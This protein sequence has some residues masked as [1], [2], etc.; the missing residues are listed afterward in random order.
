VGEYRISRRARQDLLDIYAFTASVFGSY[1]ADAYHSGLERTFALIA[2]FPLI[3]G[4]AEEIGS[5]LR[6]FRFQS[7][8]IFYSIRDGQILIRRLVHAAMDVRRDLFD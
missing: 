5:G 2:D 6:R 8:I 3:G 4:S 1:Q 7:H